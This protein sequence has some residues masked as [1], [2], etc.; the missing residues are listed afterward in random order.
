[1][2]V[3]GRLHT[4]AALP[5]GGWAPEPIWTLWSRENVVAVGNL[6]PALQP[7]APRY[8]EWVIPAHKLFTNYKTEIL[9]LEVELFIL[10][11]TEPLSV[12]SPL[13]L[14]LSLI[15]DTATTY[16]ECCFHVTC[17][18]ALPQ[19]STQPH[20]TYKNTNHVIYSLISAN[21]ED[22]FLY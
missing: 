4:P 15:P 3:N 11:V 16:Q 21:C 14:E 17:W 12:T 6:T 8:T 5:R 9:Q 1:M 13:P 10:V 19:L 18:Y 7:V 20:K 22:V 2:H